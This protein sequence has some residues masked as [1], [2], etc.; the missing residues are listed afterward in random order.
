MEVKIKECG[1]YRLRAGKGASAALR[2]QADLSRDSVKMCLTKRSSL[3]WCRESGQWCFFLHTLLASLLLFFKGSWL[4]PWLLIGSCKYKMSIQLCPAPANRCMGDGCGRC[5]SSLISRR[6]RA[7]AELR[8]AT[9]WFRVSKFETGRE[10]DTACESRPTVWELKVRPRRLGWVC[11]TRQLFFSHLTLTEP[12]FDKYHR[13][14]Q[15]PL[16]LNMGLCQIHHLN[17]ANRL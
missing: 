14:K 7:G 15:N 1:K 4:R 12:A 11:N 9:R 13:N 6:G 17:T 3:G 8:Y 2:Y 10:R 16:W 5:S